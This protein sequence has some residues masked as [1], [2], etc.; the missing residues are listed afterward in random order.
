MKAL[1]FLFVVTAVSCVA[2]CQAQQVFNVQNGTKT[3]FYSGLEEAITKAVSG[4][5]IYLPGGLI[6]VQNDLVI[7]KKLALIGAGCD[8]DSIGGLQR[9][10]LKKK[11]DDYWVNQLNINFREG[12]NGSALI[13]CIIGDI[14]FGFKNEINEYY[15]NIENIMIMRNDIQG[16]V[17]LGV[18]G[19][20]ESNNNVKKII[21]KENIIARGIIGRHAKE[22]WINNNTL[23]NN[24]YGGGYYNS[25]NISYINNSYIYNNV[26]KE[27]NGLASL[28]ACSIENNFLY[29]EVS[30][31]TNCTFNNNAFTSNVSFPVGSNTGSNNLVSQEALK[32]FQVNDLNF[33][34]NLTIRDTSPC[35][36]AGTDGTDIGI[37]GGSTPYKARPFNPHIS[38]SIISSQTD[39][40]GKLRVDMIIQAETK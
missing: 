33:P 32:T 38:K 31:C 36:N 14:T 22:C 25:Y 30:S 35:K 40:N 37:Y 26:M 23:G 10:E 29:G 3:E 20:S 11:T 1:R 19:S 9:T 4:D 5:T 7:D 16:V 17:D 21:I 18:E 13:G 12:S 39:K 34:K 15:Q 8:I 27:C 6:E 2:V 24:G 28:K